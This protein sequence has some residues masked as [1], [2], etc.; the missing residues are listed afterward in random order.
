MTKR[1]SLAAIMLL[2]MLLPAL[3]QQIT[4]EWN[5]YPQIGATIERLIDTPDHAY[6][7]S[8]GS[9]YSYDRQDNENFVYTTN[10]RLTDN[11]IADIYYNFDKS[12]LLVAYTNGNIDLVY[13]D[14][15]TVNMPDIKDALLTVSRGINSVAFAGDRIFVGTQ[16][17]LVVFDDERHEVVESGMWNKE[18]NDVFILGDHL[19]IIQAHALMG[20]P[21]DGRHNKLESFTTYTGCSGRR[22]VVLS[23]N[24]FLFLLSSN[25]T[26]IYQ[27]SVDFAAGTGR[28]VNLNLKATGDMQK[29]D[30]GVYAVV[31]N[32]IRFFGP[33]GQTTRSIA[34][35]A[36]VRGERASMARGPEAVWFAGASG[37]SCYNLSGAT[38]DLIHDSFRPNAMTCVTPAMMQW[39][40]DGERLYINNVTYTRIYDA[41]GVLGQQA[42]M[43]ENGEISDVACTSPKISYVG[44]M[45]EDPDDPSVTY[46]ASY[47]DGLYVVRDGKKVHLFDR[48]N[49][50]L[51]SG[52]GCRL[53]GVG[54]DREGNLWLSN[55]ND[56]KNGIAPY[57]VLPASKRKGNLTA[58]KSS[59]WL[60]PS[61]IPSTYA[62]TD[63]CR[64]LFCRNSRVNFFTSSGWAV[65][66]MAMDDNGTPLVFSDDKYVHHG[67]V[68]DTEGNTITRSCTNTMVE[69]ANGSVWIGT[70]QG[71]YVIDN[72]TDALSPSL[73]VRRPLVPRNDGTNFGDYLLETE[74][75]YA[76]AVDPTNRKW[77]ATGSSG[78]YLVSERGDR[79]IENFT[80]ANSPLPSNTVYS[81][82]CDPHSNR[83]FFGT[84]DGV[85]SYSSD[86]APAADDYSDV[87]A[88]PNPVRP[89]YTGWITVTGLMDNSLV[90]IADIAGNVLHQGRSEGGIFT[91]DGCNAAG[92]RVRS[93]VYLVLASQNADGS[94]SGVVTKITVIN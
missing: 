62:P 2:S 5:I 70:N 57:V 29:S 81:I 89:D 13:D 83:V 16:F 9:L 17:G 34:V 48:S 32:D 59:D 42:S 39:S 55:W 15:R 4:G 91:W 47:I 74:T 46:V 3:A 72:P 92:Q 77:I 12:Y 28:L 25:L 41:R 73:T 79:I 58:L 30:A 21:L 60:V 64:I 35:P 26:D 76:I 82:A 14:G 67:S 38:P 87:Y 75:I 23:D 65:G 11:G 94:S 37:I 45:L 63:D 19:M 66:I 44:Q 78:V 61:P 8:A 80:T 54:L 36:A 6:Y 50:P 33:D 86:S 24:S 18:V 27:A 56:Q 88:F 51:Q 69:D 71:L 31:G 68:T 22:S 85:V 53:S 20:A 93:G 90:K 52:W 43:I 7:L 10:N 40:A 49:T 84:T 1:I